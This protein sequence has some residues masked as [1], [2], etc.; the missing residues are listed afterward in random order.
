M[1][2]VVESGELEA[3]LSAYRRSDRFLSPEHVRTMTELARAIKR[4][5]ERPRRAQSLYNIADD[6]GRPVTYMRIWNRL[7]AARSARWI[8]SY[9]RSGRKQG[10][11]PRPWRMRRNC[12]GY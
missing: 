6:R 12:S 11:P 10:A 8:S 5:L 1:V 9:V 7:M 3:L 2:D 4:A